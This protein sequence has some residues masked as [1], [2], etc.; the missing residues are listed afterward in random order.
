M[1]ASTALTQQLA[2]RSEGALRAAA[3]A[4]FPAVQQSE[5][6]AGGFE[7][8][9][10]DFSDA[11]ITQDAAKLDAAAGEG[12]PVV[13]ALDAIAALEGLSLERVAEARQLS[14]VARQFLATAGRVSIPRSSPRRR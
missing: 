10:K 3:D 5:A 2:M 7:R 13:A 8:T 4:L 14:E 12:R 6:A 11:V 1:V 9:V